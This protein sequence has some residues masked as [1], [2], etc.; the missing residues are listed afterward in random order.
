MWLDDAKKKIEAWR[1][2]YNEHRPHSA[3]GNLAQKLRFIWPGV[4]GQMKL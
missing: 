2:N 3:L 1:V 4:P